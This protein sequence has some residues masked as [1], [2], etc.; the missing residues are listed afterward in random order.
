MY[1]CIYLF[2]Y[3]YY[4][5]VEHTKQEEPCKRQKDKLENASDNCLFV[6]WGG[7]GGMSHDTDSVTF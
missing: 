3:Y 4:Y 1:V 2:I 6:G 5:F 7:K